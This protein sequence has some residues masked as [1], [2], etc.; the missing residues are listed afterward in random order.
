MD[1]KISAFFASY[2]ASWSRHAAAFIDHFVENASAQFH[3][4]DGKKVELDSRAEMFAF[5][6]PS[7]ESLQSKP[8]VG[9]ATEI[10]RTQNLSFNLALVDG[11]ALITEQNAE[12]ATVT[13]R[14]WA[15]SFLLTNTEQGWKVISLR[16][17]D[18]PLA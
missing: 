13:V 1:N 5:C 10:N 12:G 8:T 3:A 9:H 18:R 14:K 15:V 6:T 7:F 16:A 4:L 17:S 11:G 2:D